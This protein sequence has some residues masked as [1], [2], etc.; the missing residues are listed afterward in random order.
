[1]TTL[2]PLDNNAIIEADTDEWRAFARVMK[3]ALLM[4]VRYLERRYRV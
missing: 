1:M 3:A 2:T 4:I